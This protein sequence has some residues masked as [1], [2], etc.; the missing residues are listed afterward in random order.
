LDFHSRPEVVGGI[1]AR[2]RVFS[3]FAGGG[4][5]TQRKFNLAGGGPMKQE[6]RFWLRSPGAVPEE[7]HYLEPG[8]GNLRGYADGT[9][10]VNKLLTANAELG[11]KVKLF[12]LE[13]KLAKLIGTTSWYGFYDVGWILDGD[14]PIQTSAR[15]TSLVDA[16]V[17]DARLENAGVGIRSNVAWPFWN[18]TWRL[19][20]P[21]W[22][23][24]PGVNGESDYVDYRYLFSLNATF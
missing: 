20:V 12:G 9:F 3:G 1:D 17:L 23:S 14:N 21:F 7:L 10:G 6:E 18:F 4:L 11:T 5:P 13:K 2:A 15:V 16:G 24:H 22:V 19:D 8:D